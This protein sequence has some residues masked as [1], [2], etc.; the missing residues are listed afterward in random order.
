MQDDVTERMRAILIDWLVEVHLKF[1]GLP[2]TQFQ[3]VNIIDRFLMQR[4]ISRKKLQLQGIS[5][6]QIACKFEEIYPPEISDFVYITD[7]VYII[8]NLLI[9]LKKGP[10]IIAT[11]CLKLNA[12]FKI[13]I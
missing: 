8:K 5:A 4:H 9:S 7:N 2:Q 1:K 10:F 12:K 6:M 13:Q 3:T 11:M